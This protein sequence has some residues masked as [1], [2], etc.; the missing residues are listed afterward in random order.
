MA[1]TCT[2][3]GRGAMN[4]VSRSHS[5]IATKRKQHV[6]L[7]TLLVDGKRVKACTSCIRTH[8]QK[9]KA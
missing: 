8:N 7:Q 9:Q 3:C 4:A 2:I 6:N 5:N 1:R